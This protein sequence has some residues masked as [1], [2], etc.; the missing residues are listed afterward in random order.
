MLQDG[1]QDRFADA[2]EEVSSFC[3]GEPRVSQKGANVGEAIMRVCEVSLD[4]VGEV[5]GRYCGRM[6]AG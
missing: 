2:T 1:V 5:L 6:V 3:V 4:V